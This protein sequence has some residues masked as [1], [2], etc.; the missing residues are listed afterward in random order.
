MLPDGEE[1]ASERDLPGQQRRGQFLDR[2]RRV[3]G[4]PDE[5]VSAGEPIELGQGLPILLRG[6]SNA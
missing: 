3:P 1:G 4:N 6:A 5:L 2:S